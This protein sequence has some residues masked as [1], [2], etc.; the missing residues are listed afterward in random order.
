[1]VDS[2][3]GRV[4]RVLV[5]VEGTKVS[6]PVKNVLEFC[7]VSR[8]LDAQ[9][10]IATSIAVFVRGGTDGEPGARSNQ[11]L[12][13]T[14][15]VGLDAHSI[16]E[17]FSFDPQ[18]IGG[19]RNLVKRLDPDIIQTH[20]TKSHFLVRLSGLG[21]LYRWIAFH[22]GYTSEGVRM[23]LYDQLDRWSLRAPSQVVTVCE[24]FKRQLVLRG[25][26]SSRILVLHNAISVDWLS[27]RE[28]M[29]TAA[30][31]S[32]QNIA[33]NLRG[34]ERVV[35]A[36]GRLSREKA[37]TDLVLAVSQLG[38]LRPDLLVRLLI[39]G[40]GPERG[41]IER[42]VHDLDLED[43]VTLAG[44]VR[45]V[46]PYFRSADVLAISS[47][48]EGSPNVL[49]EAM[50]AGVPVAATAVGGIPD[51]VTDKETGLLI[52]PRNPQA[53]AS[54]INLLFSNSDLAG[55]LTRNAKELIRN[56]Y[57]P[58]DRARFLLKLYQKVSRS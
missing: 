7:R 25:V 33:N 6:G 10:V 23:R 5:V 8:S 38:R 42:V 54:A 47:V 29:D 56:A 45:D 26:L 48:S 39:V 44:H 13:A 1:M 31:A 49:L 27:G 51:I 43:R 17:R 18:V 3:S 21:R 4:I 22:H 9:P 35:L 30:A 57:S 41:R 14:T 46:R 40:D 53:M 37:F 58:E 36:V 12:D 11:V 52:E 20:H 16:P 24:A 32:V 55:T 28:Q 19:L 15:A 34:Q 2:S 50:A